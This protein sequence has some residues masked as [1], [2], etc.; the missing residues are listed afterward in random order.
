[1]KKIVTHARNDKGRL[2]VLSKYCLFGFTFFQVEIDS[3][4]M[5]QGLAEPA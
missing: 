3:S 1:M 4:L 5:H 2:V